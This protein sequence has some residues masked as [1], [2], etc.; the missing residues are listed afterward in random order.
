MR[1]KAIEKVDK[2][3][4]DRILK[5]IIISP[6]GCWE[7]TGNKGSGYGKIKI[8]GEEFQTHRLMYAYHNNGLK[9]GFLICHSCDNTPCCNPD[10]LFIGTQQENMD[11]MKIK[12]RGFFSYG[13]KS[14]QF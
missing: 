14:G 11:D 13:E 10:N 2:Q 6:N 1:T 9:Q 7:F 3:T 8:K 12:N 5:R 4:I